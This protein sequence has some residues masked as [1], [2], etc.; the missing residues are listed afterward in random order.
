[1]PLPSRDDAR[2]IAALRAIVAKYD[3]RWD[4]APAKRY[5]VGFDYV[6]AGW[7]P[8]VEQLVLKLIDLGWDRRVAQV[9]S[10]FGRLRF[11][12][13]SGTLPMFR[14]IEQAERRSL[15]MC[16]R[17]GAPGRY[18]NAACAVRCAA[19]KGPEG[20]RTPIRLVATARGLALP[21]RDRRGRRR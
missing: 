21:A 13:G 17:C 11:Y 2:D 20:Q 16:E 1:M 14:A 18:D 9:K 4:D 3:L 8:L 7:A 12:I 15:R 6:G 10:K 19:H 5:P